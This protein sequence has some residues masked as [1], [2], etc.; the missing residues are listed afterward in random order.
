MPLLKQVNDYAAG[1]TGGSERE[2]AALRAA[3]QAA[4][5]AA[6]VPR[7]KGT[8]PKAPKQKPGQGS[9]SKPS[10]RPGARRPVWTDEWNA[11]PRP[12]VEN[13]DEQQLPIRGTAAKVTGACTMQ[14]KQAICSQTTG[15]PTLAAC[16]WGGRQV[17]RRAKSAL[18]AHE[19]AHRRLVACPT[20]RPHLAR[21]LCT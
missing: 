19:P 5:A 9:D 17:V 12:A 16:L 21:V 18:H 7:P 2:A 10:S 6:G 13:L 11:P 14:C 3:A 20:A 4:V 8:P 15:L 1:K